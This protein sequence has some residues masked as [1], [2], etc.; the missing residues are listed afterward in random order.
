MLAWTSSSGISVQAYRTDVVAEAL[1][2]AGEG[3]RGRRRGVSVGV[4]MVVSQNKVLQRF[5]EQIIVDSYWA[6]TGFDSAL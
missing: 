1:A 5:V 3:G 2:V 4:L 6:W